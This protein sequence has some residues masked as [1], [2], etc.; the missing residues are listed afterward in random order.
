MSC[1]VGHR[2]G[3]DPVLL[4]CRPAAVALIPLLAWEPP[5]AVGAARKKKKKM[6]ETVKEIAKKRVAKRQ[7]ILI[8]L[9]RNV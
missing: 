5:Y 6:K 1:G 7:E 3:L 2:C 4:W 9:G 8:S